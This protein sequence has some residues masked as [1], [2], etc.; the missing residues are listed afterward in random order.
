MKWKKEKKNVVQFNRNP[1]TCITI[2][3]YNM[4]DGDE[5]NTRKVRFVFNITFITK[6]LNIT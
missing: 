6:I 3:K 5:K 2:N 4:D 1:N